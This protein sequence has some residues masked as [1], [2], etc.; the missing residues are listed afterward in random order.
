[1]ATTP[2]L[3]LGL[4]EDGSVGWGSS[5]RD[6]MAKLDTSL[7]QAGTVSEAIDNATT[8]RDSASASAGGASISGG[9]AWTTLGASVE[10]EVGPAGVALV[11]Q[12]VQWSADTSNDTRAADLGISWSGASSG[13]TRAG[14][15]LRQRSASLRHFSVFNT[16]TIV[17]TGLTP[18]TTTFTGEARISVDALNIDR[19]AIEVLT[20]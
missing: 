12:H 8:L 4:P 5:Y 11:V 17:L 19:D 1:M 9:S 16:H 15:Y 13:D 2:N 14:R 3:G 20:W 7:D 10:V 6:A 18:G